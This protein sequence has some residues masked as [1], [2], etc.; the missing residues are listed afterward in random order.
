VAFESL[1]LAFTSAPIL[2]I[3]DPYS[4][5]ILECD[6]SNFALGAVLSQICKKDGKLHPVAYL[7]WSLIDLERNYEVFD[8]ELLAIVAAFKEWRQ[9]LEGNPQRLTAIVYTDHR[10]LESFMTTKQLTR[11]QAQWAE[12]MR[13]FDFEIIFRLGRQATKPDALS[14]CPDLA[15]LKGDNLTFGQFLQPENVTPRTFAE[16][17]AFDLDSWFV[18][19]TVFLDNAKHWFHV[20]VLG[21]KGPREEP[22]PGMGW[23][24]IELISQI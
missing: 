23:S 21:D 14:R 7:S 9:F 24:D 6:C 2:K 18:D 12:T 22:G 3:A 19:G 11:Q 16:V 15:P 5:F 4:P 1:K 13:C 10:N 20:N 8:K 17:S